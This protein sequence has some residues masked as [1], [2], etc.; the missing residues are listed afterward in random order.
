MD[1][2]DKEYE[3]T[4]MQTTLAHKFKWPAKEDIIWVHERQI[5]KQVNEPVGEGKNKRLFGLRGDDYRF[6]KANC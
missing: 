5:L 3:I 1:D 6:F 4:F 2:D